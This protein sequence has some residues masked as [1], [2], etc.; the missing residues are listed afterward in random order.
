MYNSDP[1][2]AAVKLLSILKSRSLSLMSAESMIRPFFVREDKIKVPKQER[3]S[4]LS[5]LY[6]ENIANQRIYGDGVIVKNP[7]AVSTVGSDDG[8]FRIITEAYTASAARDIVGE[9]IKKLNI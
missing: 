7:N 6:E 1:L 5:R 2:C 4:S 3:A 9:I 8:G